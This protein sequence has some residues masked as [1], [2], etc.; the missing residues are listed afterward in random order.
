MSPATKNLPVLP[1]WQARSFWLTLV[2]VLSP[3]LSALGLD[4]PW[5]TN[6]ATIDLIMSLVVSPAAAVFAWRERLAPS[7]RLG[8]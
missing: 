3:V 4:W 2:A 8:L 6:P 1:F 7:F 5:V